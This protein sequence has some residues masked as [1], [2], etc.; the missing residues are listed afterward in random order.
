MSKR[1]FKRCL[2]ADK[3]TANLNF[4]NKSSLLNQTTNFEYFNVS[5]DQYSTNVCNPLTAQTT[6]YPSLLDNLNH[7]HKLTAVCLTNSPIEP[8]NSENITL[9]DKLWQLICDSYFT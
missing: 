6:M 4:N 1:N 8:I 3:K 9:K 7:S 2:E 5:Q